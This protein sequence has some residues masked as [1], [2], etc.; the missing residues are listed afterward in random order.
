MAVP[1]LIAAAIGLAALGGAVECL[2]P[3]A[4][5]HLASLLAP[6][7]VVTLTYD[8]DRFDRYGRVLAGVEKGDVLVNAEMARQGLGVAVE[9]PRTTVSTTRSSRP[10]AK[11]RRRRPGCTRPPSPAPCRD[12]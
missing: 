11:P 7:D 2:G 6:G 12:G 3:E 8:E 1:V 5:A 10:S 9:Y 4:S